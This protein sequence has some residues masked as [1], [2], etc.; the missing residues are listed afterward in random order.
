MEKFKVIVVAAVGALT[1][2]LGVLAIPVYLLVGC[3][4]IDYITGLIASKYRGEKLSSY[5]GIKGIA[6]KVCQW[7]LIIVGSWIDILIQYAV[8]SAGIPLEFPFIVAIVVAI[9]LV[10]NEM[11]SILENMV[12]IG[13]DM[14]PFLMPIVKRIKHVTEE[15]IKEEEDEDSN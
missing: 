12:D 11:I 2:F 6:K 8:E 7:L 14:P 15:Q 1:S 9:W 10:L 13:V 5:K 3:N 4:V